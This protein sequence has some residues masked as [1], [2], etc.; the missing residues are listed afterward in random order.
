[1]SSR[2]GKEDII[3]DF[4]TLTYFCQKQREGEEVRDEIIFLHSSLASKIEKIKLEV[5]DSLGNFLQRQS[6]G[7]Q[8]YKCIVID[9]TTGIEYFVLRR[10]Y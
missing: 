9:L 7:P 3:N 6:L 8:P 1:M 10:G 2:Y 5:H 4:Q